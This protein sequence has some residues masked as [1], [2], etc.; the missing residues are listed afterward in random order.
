MSR[1]LL[2][3]VEQR[4][5]SEISHSLKVIKNE[6]KKEVSGVPVK[7]RWRS[8]HTDKNYLVEGT[9]IDATLDVDNTISFTV[10]FVDPDSSAGGSRMTVRKATEFYE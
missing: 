7:F 5:R 8:P 9:V 1:S 6:L 10:K 4:Y 2:S 3:L